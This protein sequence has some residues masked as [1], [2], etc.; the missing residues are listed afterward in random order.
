MSVE[1]IFSFMHVFSLNLTPTIDAVLILI[2][3]ELLWLFVSGHILLIV[4]SLLTPTIG[5]API[6]IVGELL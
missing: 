6:L 4:L 5:A 1:I 3:G 2:A